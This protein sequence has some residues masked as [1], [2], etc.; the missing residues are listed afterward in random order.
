MEIDSD[1]TSTRHRKIVGE[2]GKHLVCNWVS[3]SGFEVTIADHT[4]LDL[5]AYDPRAKK[6]LGITVK[7]RSR[8]KQSE[9]HPVTLFKKYR[10]KTDDRQKLLDA[11]KAFGCEPWLAVYVETADFA[12]LYLTSLAHYDATYRGE[13]KAVDNWSMSRRRK[14]QYAND[15]EVKHIMMKFQETNW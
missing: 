12:D 8:I 6:R 13:G 9:H 11:C 7:T 4:G 1:R 3:R 15:P 5:I 14:K 2:Y 10:N